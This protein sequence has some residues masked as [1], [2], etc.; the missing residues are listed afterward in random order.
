MQWHNRSVL[1][2][3]G[4]GFIG[5]HLC[6][7][8]ARAGARVTVFARY[9][10]HG[11]IGGLATIDPALRSRINLIFGDLRDSSAVDAAIAGSDV[12]FHLAAHI[13]IPY[14]YVHPLDVVQ[15]NVLG[16]AHVLEACRRHGVSKAVLFSTSEV[17]GTARYAPID[18]EHP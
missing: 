3:G 11:H 5:S 8:L 7:A 9:T 13:G 18:E 1:V 16:T 15:V 14:S 10:S 2:T 4:C 12:V 17:Y 6:E